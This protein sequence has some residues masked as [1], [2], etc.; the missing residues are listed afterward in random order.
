MERTEDHQWEIGSWYNINLSLGTL[1]L[2]SSEFEMVTNA[3]WTVPVDCPGKSNMDKAFCNCSSLYNRWK[4]KKNIF[5]WGS[6]CITF[7]TSTKMNWFYIF[8][9]GYYFCTYSNSIRVPM[10]P[11]K[12]L[13]ELLQ[14]YLKSF[15][16]K[17]SYFWWMN[18]QREKIVLFSS[19]AIPN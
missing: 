3:S 9:A 8:K 18:H 15:D 19:K 16:Q 4:N 14:P 17:S 11:L 13:H 1:L 7:Y 6:T 10:G 2:F 5:D 12:N